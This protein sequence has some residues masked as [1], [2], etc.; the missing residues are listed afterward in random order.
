MT[1]VTTVL[2][3]PSV[4]LYYMYVIAFL[5]ESACVQKSVEFP[6]QKSLLQSVGEPLATA[7]VVN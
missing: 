4:F 1:G 3:S 6:S 7:T 5:Q 2:Y